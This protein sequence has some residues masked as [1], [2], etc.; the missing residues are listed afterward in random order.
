MQ[1]SARQP[2]AVLFF[3]AV[4]IAD[5]DAE[6]DF[7]GRRI[8]AVESGSSQASGI[9]VRRVRIIALCSA[10][11]GCADRPVHGQPHGFRDLNIGWGSSQIRSRCRGGNDAAAPAA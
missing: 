8:Y 1:I 11:D 5:P 3:S 7:L 2:F 4:L 6:E 9:P 10:V